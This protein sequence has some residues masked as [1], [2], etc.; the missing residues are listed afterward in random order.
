MKRGEWKRRRGD[1]ER[2]RFLLLVSPSPCPLV[3][4]SFLSP[5]DFHP[6]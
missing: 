3:S 5:F 6:L 1:K 2:K 4:P